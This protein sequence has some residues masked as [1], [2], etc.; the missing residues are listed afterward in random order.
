[1][2]PCLSNGHFLTGTQMAWLGAP[3][4]SLRHVTW[5]WA[6]WPSQGPWL[7]WGLLSPGWRGKASQP[8]LGWGANASQP[9]SLGGQGAAVPRL[10]GQN[11]D[12]SSVCHP[13]PWL[14]E[15]PI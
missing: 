5:S 12:R 7:A 6:H 3:S 1:M 2:D 8:Q 15:Y 14:G 4:D 9:E 10:A 11:P 13:G